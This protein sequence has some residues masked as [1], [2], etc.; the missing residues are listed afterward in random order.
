MNIDFQP[1]ASLGRMLYSFTATAIEVDAANTMNY[2]KY[3]IQ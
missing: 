3:N 1:I 2:D